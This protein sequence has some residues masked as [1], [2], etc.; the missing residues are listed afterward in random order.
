ML[1]AILLHFVHALCSWRSGQLQ[2]CFKCSPKVGVVFLD[3][4]NNSVEDLVKHERFHS[5]ELKNEELSFIL[6]AQISWS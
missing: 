1:C 2:A 4:R 3:S 5:H 6:S